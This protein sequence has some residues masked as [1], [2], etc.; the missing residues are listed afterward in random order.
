[1]SPMKSFRMSRSLTNPLIALGL[2]L[3]VGCAPGKNGGPTD[4]AAQ[5]KLGN[6]YSEGKW[7]AQDDEEAAKWFR[8]AAIQGNPEGQY[9]LAL[10]Y[11]SG[12]G[13]P[14][15]DALAAEWY[16]KAANQGHSGAQYRLGLCYDLHEGVPK[17]LVMAYMWLN[18]AAASGDL[19]ARNS[20]EAIARRMTDAQIAKAQQMSADWG[21]N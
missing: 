20:R 6:R 4:A 11:S 14:K 13:M 21:R 1:M 10:C 17:D 12:Y 19:S 9:H 3:P 8:K 16:Q 2:L 5:V 7:V 15:N 18:L